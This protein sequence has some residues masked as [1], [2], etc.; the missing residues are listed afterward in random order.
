MFGSTPKQ[1]AATDKPAC[2]GL[3]I[4]FWESK[5]QLAQCQSAQWQSGD[6]FRIHSLFSYIV[7]RN[8]AEKG[9][10]G[11]SRGASDES[12]LRTTYSVSLGRP[13]NCYLWCCPR[14]KSTESKLEYQTGEKL[15][16]G[17]EAPAKGKKRTKLVKNTFHPLYGEMKLQ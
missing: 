8:G 13:E 17:L 2:D 7:N 16:S 3:L 10:L 4:F 1:A 12:M 6:A 15:P 5:R 9:S 11:C 14:K